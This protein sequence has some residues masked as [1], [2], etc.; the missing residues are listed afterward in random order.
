MIH[1]VTFRIL[2]IHKIIQAGIRTQGKAEM[3]F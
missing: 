2:T 3:K 1:T